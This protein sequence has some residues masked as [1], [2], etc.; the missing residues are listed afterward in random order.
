[1]GN[2]ASICFIHIDDNRYPTIMPIKLRENLEGGA[3]LKSFSLVLR[4]LRKGGKYCRKGWP[5]DSFITYCK[6]RGGRKLI[7][8]TQ[9]GKRF[10]EYLASSVDMLSDDWQE[11]I[12]SINK[13]GNK[14][15]VIL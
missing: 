8:V 14:T 11:M 3:S 13:D 15:I 12:I 5:K 10:T 2:N 9:D 7:G 1:M 6:G 4:D